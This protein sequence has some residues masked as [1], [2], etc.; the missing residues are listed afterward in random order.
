[1][2]RPIVLATDFSAVSDAAVPHAIELAQLWKAP[3]RLVHVIEAQASGGPWLGFSDALEE[4]VGERVVTLLN[5][6]AAQIADSGITVE[7]V[8]RRGIPADEILAELSAINAQ[9]VV[10]GSHGHSGFRQFFIGSVATRVARG[11]DCPVL[12]VPPSSPPPPWAGVLFPTDFSPL[13]NAVFP[14]A[15]RLAATADVPLEIFHV[16]VPRDSALMAYGMG[17]A[18]IYELDAERERLDKRMAKL[19]AQA[20][21]AG[22]ATTS[23]R[24]IG[25]RPGRGIVGRAL[26]EGHGLI[27]MPANGRRGFARFMYGSVT[28]EVMRHIDRPLMILPGTES[29]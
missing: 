2:T 24:V 1:M 20:D 6:R 11:A 23:V 9:A 10:L 22:V 4:N 28:E 26:G 27:V 17:D 29:E 21:E 5:E 14:E 7:L 25:H 18:L 15:I 3:L 12:V 8:N 19:S 16:E 13:C